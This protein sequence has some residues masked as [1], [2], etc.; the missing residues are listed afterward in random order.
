MP[1][2]DLIRRAKEEK[3]RRILESQGVRVAS[4]SNPPT[5]AKIEATR[6]KGIP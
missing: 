1:T 6:T 3:A 5:D 2:Q 4:L